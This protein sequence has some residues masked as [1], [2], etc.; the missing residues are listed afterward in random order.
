[1]K[2]RPS[3]QHI[4]LAAAALVVLA[5]VM[6]GLGMRHGVRHETNSHLVVG[7]LLVVCGGLTAIAG[8]AAVLWT[9]V[10]F[11]S[12]SMGLRL[13]SLLVGLFALFAPWQCFRVFGYFAAIAERKDFEQAGPDQ[14][15]LAAEELV[16]TAPQ[17]NYGF[18]W[19]GG[20]VPPEEVPPVIRSFVPNAAYVTVDEDGVVIVTDGLGGSRSGYMI[21]PSGSAFVPNRSRRIT[22][23]FYYVTSNGDR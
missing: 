4:W 23:G 1:M 18:R 14:L 9:C 7:F 11:A 3:K 13:V 15:R 17:K 20:E 19:F 16:R 8:L 22:D 5:F 10:S 12:M 6:T 2:S 21:T